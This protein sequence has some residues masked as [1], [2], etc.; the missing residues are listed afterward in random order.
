MSAPFKQLHPE[1]SSLLLQ[2]ARVPGFLFRQV[3]GWSLDFLPY[4]DLALLKELRRTTMADM[5]QKRNQTSFSSTHQPT[6]RVGENTGLVP[7]GRKPPGKA[8][9]GRP[10]G[11]RNK[12]TEAQEAFQRLGYNPT[13]IQVAL[14]KQIAEMLEAGVDDEGNKLTMSKR[15]S[16]IKQLATL[17]EVLMQ[18]QSSKAAPEV[19]EYFAGNDEDYEDEEST[20][21]SRPLSQ[22]QLMDSRKLMTAKQNLF[23][24]LGESK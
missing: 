3:G 14:A 5:P 1:D 9:P 21:V 24:R 2:N 13:E 12:R 19:E 8:G 7:K 20:E 16:L 17:N 4:S 23:N 18:Y 6:S 10:K 22:K 15:C 11:R